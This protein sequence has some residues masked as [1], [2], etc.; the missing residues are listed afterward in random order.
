MKLDNKMTTAQLA[1][2][3]IASIIGVL[4]TIGFMSTK[5]DI[6]DPVISLLFV[7]ISLAIVFLLR[8][9]VLSNINK[10]GKLAPKKSNISGK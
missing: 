8:R 7:L 2:W 9:F 5:A 3:T 4:G 6:S 1:I 10:N